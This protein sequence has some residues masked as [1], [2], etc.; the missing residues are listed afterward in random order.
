MK[1]RVAY[2]AF[3]LLSLCLFTGMSTGRLPHRVPLKTLPSSASSN[4]N[5]CTEGDPSRTTAGLRFVGSF[6]SADYTAMT[7]TFK[8]KNGATQNWPMT[9]SSLPKVREM[10]EGDL[11]SLEYIPEKPIARN[12]IPSRP[13]VSVSPTTG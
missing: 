4:V 7:V 3:I 5:S 13:I 1:Y 2:S 10:K 11:L 9:E 8:L 12:Q 6:V